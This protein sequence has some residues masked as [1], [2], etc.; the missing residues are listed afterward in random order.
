LPVCRAPLRSTTGVSAKACRSARSMFRRITVR[1]SPETGELARPPFPLLLHRHQVSPAQ[2]ERPVPTTQIFEAIESPH[3]AK[4]RVQLS[5][6]RA[7]A[8]A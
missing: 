5:K 4:V 2:V 1:Y 8:N 3:A 7:D 6:G